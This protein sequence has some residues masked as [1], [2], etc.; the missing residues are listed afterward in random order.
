MVTFL[1]EARGEL[2]SLIRTYA[3][4]GLLSLGAITALAAWQAGRLLAPLRRLNDTAREISSSDLS[5]R[6]PETG[7]DDITDLTRT[8][9]QMLS[10]LESSFSEQ[11]RFLDD[12]GHELRTP[13]TVLRGHLELL[14]SDNPEDVAE[15]QALLLDEV[16]RMSRLVED[17]TLLAKSNRPDFLNL[18]DVDLDQLTRTAFAKAMALGDRA[19]ELEGVAQATTRMDP[20]RVTQAVLQLADNAVKHTDP[21]ERIVIGSAE[22]DGQIRIWVRDSGDGVDEADQAL[23]FERFERAHVRSGDAGFGLGLSIVKAIAVAHGG[24]VTV[25]DADPQGAEFTLILPMES[26]KELSWPES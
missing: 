24:D 8:L 14:Q 16:D 13:L 5:S 11:R 3:I 15:T 25:S 20:Q 19:W 26:A 9:N 6:I 7:N 4:V 21:G 10:R 18:A 2:T 12:A 17:M 1:D 23:I 22:Q